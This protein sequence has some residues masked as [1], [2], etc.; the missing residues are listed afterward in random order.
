M[1]DSYKTLSVILVLLTI[2]T[3]YGQTP[4][5]LSDTLRK[6]IYNNFQELKTNYPSIPLEHEV[7][8]F[9]EVKD[10]LKLSKP[11]KSYKLNIDKSTGKEFGEV[12]GFCDGKHV[13]INPNEPKLRP[14]TPFSKLESLN[15][16]SYFES[17]DC[18]VDRNYGT[19][20]E[21]RRRVLDLQTGEVTLLTLKNFMELISDDPGLKKQF[22]K[23]KKKKQV[24]DDYIW[25]YVERK[26]ANK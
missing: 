11:A 13:Y 21:R 22:K 9:E 16:L 6:G 7:Q 18:S 5:Y 4:I 15:A 20:C 24:L 12:Y 23:E 19:N 25:M 1:K 26:R 10:L 3:S 17:N 14:N 8:E 2:S